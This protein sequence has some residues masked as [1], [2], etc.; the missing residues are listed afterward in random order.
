MERTPSDI[1]LDNIHATLHGLY[2]NPLDE[3][4]ALNLQIDLA[5]G[6][7]DPQFLPW[8]A[9]MEEVAARI[10]YSLT[11]AAPR[12]VRLDRSVQRLSEVQHDLIQIS[13]VYNT[14][15]S[16]QMRGTLAALSAIVTSCR[17]QLRSVAREDREG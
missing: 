13:D 14:A 7:S 12:R 17:D 3:L 11:P 8:I 5:R 6:S 9:R 4:K 2:D 16:P 1:M 10:K 15:T